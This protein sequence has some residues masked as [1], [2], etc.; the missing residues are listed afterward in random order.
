M[1]LLIERIWGKCLN[2]FRTTLVLLSLW[3][4]LLSLYMYD[5]LLSLCCDRPWYSSPSLSHS[6][7]ATLSIWRN[8]VRRN[9]VHLIHQLNTSLRRTYQCLRE[10]ARGWRS[11]LERSLRKRKIGCSI[12][13]RDRHKSYKQAV[14]ATLPN[15]RQ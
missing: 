5:M 7:I 10:K 9:D 6:P 4:V 2:N 14:I 3:S 1:Q 15:T 13:S 8:D 12:P 11:W